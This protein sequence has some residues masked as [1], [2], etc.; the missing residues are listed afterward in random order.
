LSKLPK[1]LTG[2]LPIPEQIEMLSRDE[3]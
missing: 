2:Q 1:D 3:G